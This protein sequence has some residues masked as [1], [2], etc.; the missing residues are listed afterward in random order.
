V[1]IRIKTKIRFN[2]Q[3]YSSARDLP[4]EARAAYEKAMRAPAL[5]TAHNIVING[6]EFAGEMDL[7]PGEKKLYDDVL[8]LIQDNGEVTLPGV[9]HAEPLLTPRQTRLVL[10]LAGLLALAAL[11]I[12]SR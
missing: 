6:Q 10:F 2:G 1:H 5:V 4:V 11:V 7:P 9:H 12:L 8:A 3:E